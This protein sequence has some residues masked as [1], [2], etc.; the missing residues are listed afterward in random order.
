[1][2]L[3]RKILIAMGAAVVTLTVCTARSTWDDEAAKRKADY[4]F[5]RACGANALD[6]IDTGSRLLDRAAMLNPTDVTISGEQAL[7]T[8]SQESP[9]SVS[10][11][12]AY[13]QLNDLYNS[14]NADYHTGYM[15]GQ[16]AGY[17]RDFDN[18]VRVWQTLDS[19]F[20]AKT[21]P[22]VNL[23]NAYVK[24]YLTKNDTTDFV[25]AMTIFDRL[26]SG[27][28]KDIGLTSQKV[29]AYA[30]RNDTAAIVREINDLLREKPADATAYLYAGS[31]YDNFRRDS[32][33]LA[34][35]KYACQLDSANGRA[36][37]SLA[38]FYRQ[39]G[40]SVAYDREVFQA[41]QSSN[42]EFEAKYEIMRGYVSE[43]YSDT[44]QWG[45]IEHLFGVLEEENPG[46]A[47]V[48]LLYGAFENVRDNKLAAYE[49]F[50]YAMG[51]DPSDGS[52][53]MTVIQL[54]LANDSLNSVIEV[55][56]EGMKLFPTNFYFPIMAAAGYNQQKRYDK[57]VEVLKSVDYSNVQ[58]GKA[59]SNLLCTLA[60]NYY[61]MDSL[62]L[63][64]DTYEQAIGYDADNYMAY[65][66]AGY[67]L[68]ESGRDI[69]KAM[70]YT[71]YAVL[72]EPQNA[73][74]LDSYAWALFKNKDYEKAK[75]NID[76]AIKYSSDEVVEGDT[77]IV[78]EDTDYDD[79]LIDN[80][81]STSLSA[82]I[83]AHAGDIYFM[84]GD[85]D[86]ALDFWK[87]AA[88]LKPDDELLARKV[89]H[90]T[91]FYK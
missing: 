39:R 50:S 77:L 9:D 36:F 1:M 52:V 74:Y 82:D 23:A 2:T 25:R 35:Y 16:L 91:Y 20:P 41:L 8:L 87:K 3:H 47:G 75:E 78:N 86:G 33:A 71:R 83:L 44:A 66:N 30:L 72:S 68:A 37:V 76:L 79:E 14:N 29:R 24:R 31:V 15:V 32:D 80:D 64:F 54:A 81:S 62:D 13:A 6:S 55:S 49:Q 19:V 59:V 51:L 7:M 10:M 38:N 5:L 85:P 60:D 70:R 89:K 69:E 63:A 11:A 21:D 58:N 46:E 42:L 12:K 45:R 56:K 22:A 90:K 84:S 48:H 53:R 27:T 26:E 61:L 18:E 34:N 17:L 28:G 40:D 4:V 57:A 65:N 73:T 88:A 67:F 43:L